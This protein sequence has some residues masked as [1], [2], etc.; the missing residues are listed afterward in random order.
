M[1]GHAAYHSCQVSS[2]TC[3]GCV[4]CL[5][6]VRFWIGLLTKLVITYS[7]CAAHCWAKLVSLAVTVYNTVAAR[8]EK[9]RLRLVSRSQPCKRCVACLVLL[10]H[11]DLSGTRHKE[12]HCVEIEQQ[13]A[14]KLVQLLMVCLEEEACEGLQEGSP[15]ASLALVTVSQ[16]VHLAGKRR[17][18]Y[19]TS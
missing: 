5:Q 16:A 6:V 14:P 3:C 9:C 15:A 4:F 8:C 18:S 17:L 13:L 10:A 19:A 2:W 12:Q 11:S 1:R 7:A